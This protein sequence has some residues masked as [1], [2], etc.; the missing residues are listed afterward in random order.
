M[1]ENT[2]MFTF[3]TTNAYFSLLC[4]VIFFLLNMSCAE[5]LFHTL[6][7]V[8]FHH[9][10]KYKEDGKKEM[11]V[12]LYSLLPDTIDTQHAKELTDMQSE[13]GSGCCLWT[14]YSMYSRFT[15]KKNYLQTSD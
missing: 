2:K 14:E 15:L 6:F 3:L 12:N 10:V 7:C 9:K 8:L 5:K 1:V 13:V 11:S 4:F